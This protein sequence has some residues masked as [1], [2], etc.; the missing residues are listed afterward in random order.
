MASP[1]QDPS[2]P[3]AGLLYL[4]WGQQPSPFGWHFIPC[5]QLTLAS[6]GPNPCATF[7]PSRRQFT[8]DQRGRVLSWG[9]HLPSAPWGKGGS[10]PGS[11][12]WT[13][14]ASAVAD[15]E[16][17]V[18]VGAER[19]RPG[20]WR[21]QS[22]QLSV[23]EGGNSPGAGESS[24]FKAVPPWRTPTPPALAQSL[25]GRALAAPPPADWG[26]QCAGLGA[27]VCGSER[28]GPCPARSCAG[29]GA[30]ARGCEPAAFPRAAA[31]CC[32]SAA[33]CALEERGGS[34]TATLA[35]AKWT[36]SGVRAGALQDP[37]TWRWR[38]GAWGCAPDARRRGGAGV[39][40]LGLRAEGAGRGRAL[41]AD[42]EVQRA[43]GQGIKPWTPGPAAA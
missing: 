1:F 23:E 15:G 42:Q 29:V 41:Q 28:P 16:S 26:L 21:K 25:P 35:E 9:L 5:H 27:A 12:G 14:G 24:A 10:G 7:R 4:G 39:G 2:S 38:R 37:D 17:R 22:P 33:H 34:R 30:A 8:S 40:A 32:P 36:S 19:S 3:A 18:A 43:G 13:S 31:L 11:P 6:K 20:G